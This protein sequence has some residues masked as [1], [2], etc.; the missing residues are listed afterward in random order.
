MEVSSIEYLAMAKQ[1]A[2]DFVSCGT[3]LSEAIAKVAESRDL[4]QVQIQR[5]VELSNH[6]A[7]DVMRKQ[8]DDQ[9][10]C[11]NVATLEGVLEALH[12]EGSGIPKIAAADIRMSVRDYVGRDSKD[13]LFD[14][15]EKE[16]YL[17]PAKAA[18]RVK[19]VQDNL[20]KIAQ[21]IRAYTGETDSR[22]AGIHNSIREQ[23]ESMTKHA[24]NHLADNNKLSDLKKFACS[25]FPEDGVIWDAVFDELRNRTIA[26]LATTSPM[27]R[28]LK[29]DTNTPSDEI[30]PIVINGRHGYMVEL[31]T[32]KN[33]ISEADRFSKRRNLLNTLGP[34]VVK[35][36]TEIKSSKDVDKHVADTVENYSKNV[37][38][39]GTYFK[40]MDTQYSK[41]AELMEKAAAMPFPGGGKKPL[42]LRTIALMAFMNSSAS[43]PW[44][45][46][47]A[48]G[49]K[50]GLNI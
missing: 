33:K 6:E 49:S 19:R 34:A 26:K 22:L 31:D 29:R 45:V 23:L 42:D 46:A 28:A 32:L 37:D 20:V 14:A 47:H 25:A 48:V 38:D 18:V 8:A 21:R 44:D 17:H 39:K 11:F 5:V 41:M 15:M 40:L 24:M 30:K 16:A 9:T 4:S 27:V 43:R 12:E 50:K 36:I 35:S 2:D 1:A 10:Y 13:A 7:N 3:D